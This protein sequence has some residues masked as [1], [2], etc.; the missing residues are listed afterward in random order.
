ME[1]SYTHAPFRAALAGRPLK[2]MLEIGSLHG[3]DAIEVMKTYGLDRVVTI[4]CNP[5]CIEICRK[6]FAPFPNITLVEVAAWHEDGTIPFYRVTASQDW[7]GKPTHNI[8]ASSCF[9]T[10]GSWP[11]EKYTQQRIDVPARRLDGVLA[12]LEVESVDLICMDAQGAELYALQGLGRYLDRV[13][14]IITELE[15]KP[16]YHGQTLFAEVSRFLQS[17]GFRLAAEN[18]WAETAG[19]FLFL[20]EETSSPDAARPPA[21]VVAAL[22]PLARLL[23]PADAQNAIQIAQQQLAAGRLGAAEAIV[24]AV[25]GYFPDFFPALLVQA[26]LKERAGDLQA[27]TEIYDRAIAANP[28]HAVAFT[29]RGIIKLRT[30]LGNPPKPRAAD[31]KRPF[32]L[33]TN[34]GANGRFGNQLLQYGIARTYAQKTRSQLR[35]PDWIGR[36]LFGLDDPLPGAVRAAAT[37][38]EADIL[39]VVSG[40]AATASTNVDLS[41]Y[42][43]GDTSTWAAQRA[44]FRRCFTPTAAVRQAADAGLHRLMQRGQ[45]LVALHLRRGDFGQGRYWIAP[46]SWY[47]EWLQPL[48]PTLD[49]PVLFLATDSPEV[50]SE[51]Q[52]FQPVTAADLGPP[53]PGAEFFLDHWVLRHADWLAASNST[54]SIT[55]ALLNAKARHCWRPDRAIGKLREFNP[56]ASPVLL[57]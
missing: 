57:D 50:A 34:L 23:T 14:A 41:G 28:G 20:R 30:A 10:N 46:A 18:R 21:T 33:M 9:P 55:A 16:M 24:A 53:L 48:W 51:F 8:G 11:F 45:T 37:L 29:R 56:W 17:R 12:G 32:V 22:A 43:C 36:D 1:C 54:F 3:L 42:F 5:E 2:T 35:V 7:N 15:L 49:H 31:D 27:A 38:G 13:S 26:E 19:D 25:Q 40:A 6:N 47:L 39:P 52:S 4:E 44:E